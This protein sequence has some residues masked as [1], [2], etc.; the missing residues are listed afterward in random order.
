MGRLVQ[1]VRR[2]NGIYQFIKKIRTPHGQK[3]IEFTLNVREP[4][5]AKMIAAQ[6]SA[7]FLLHRAKVMSGDLDIDQ[8]RTALAD[9][10]LSVAQS[11]RNAMFA[12]L[13]G[14]TAADQ[15]APDLQTLVEADVAAGRALE[16]IAAHGEAMRDLNFFIELLSANDFSDEEILLMVGHLY[17]KLDELL[18]PGTTADAPSQVADI[19]L[20]AGAGTNERLRP[21]I[22]SSIVAVVGKTVG[23][24][25]QTAAKHGL[26]GVRSLVDG[27]VARV[28]DQ[29]AHASALQLDP[30]TLSMSNV[31]TLTCA[32]A[33]SATKPASVHDHPFVVEAEGFLTRTRSGGDIRADKDLRAIAHLFSE[34][35][36]ERGVHDLRELQQKH[37]TG[38]QKLFKELPTS[39]GKSGR[40][41]SLVDYRKRGAKLPAAARGISPKTWNKHC[42]NLSAVIKSIRNTGGA[43]GKLGEFLDPNA[44]RM[45]IKDRGRGKR[46]PFDVAELHALF[47][48]SPFTGC[49]G[50]ERRQ[51]FE[52]GEFVY[53]RALYFAPM[54]LAYSGARRDEIC[55]LECNDVVFDAPIPYFEIRKNEQRGVKNAQSVRRL[56]IH[57][58]V[59]RLGL[60]EYVVAIQRL[61]YVL[62]FPDLHSATNTSPLGDRLYD[63]LASGLAAA[64]PEQGPR[65]KTIHSLRHAVGN[66]LKQG[67]V[68][69][70]L[71]ADLL[72]HK[73]KDTTEETYASQAPLE[74]LHE[75]IHMLPVVTGHLHPSKTLLVPWVLSKK[76]APWG[77][78]RD[79]SARRPSS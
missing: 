65:K 42:F 51:P 45:K 62:L 66:A 34:F 57:D 17:P 12:T 78:K 9:L 11:R 73:G 55:G 5:L 37:F 26:I 63:E 27:A 13:T 69:S 68:L 30:P 70:E 64:V 31:S 36:T 46:A 8:F 40:D 32:K 39:W 33:L 38:F 35:L 74:Q 49:A 10:A 15:G 59:L 23:E 56:P 50:W 76:P 16:L 6:V 25:A 71:R 72:G 47:G 21:F 48:L 52:V 60:K 19:L 4:E 77:R 67:G 18:T 2:R 20:K 53:H 61:R 79:T 41:T 43:V 29:P 22:S 28:Y 24:A 3:T 44:L 54:L 1:N 75:L 58:E 14:A 7:Q